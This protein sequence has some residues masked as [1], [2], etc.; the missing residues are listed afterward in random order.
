MVF[1]TTS[2]NIGTVIQKAAVDDLPPMEQ[3]SLKSN[4]KGVLM[5]KRWVFGW[6][7]TTLA[8]LLNMIALGYADITVIQ[9]LIGFGLVVL[10]VFSHYYLKEDVSRREIIGIAIAIV[11]VIILG[12]AASESQEFGSVDEVV[13]KYVQTSAWIVFAVFISSIAVLWIWSVKTEYKF[14]GI[15]FA[16]IAASFSVLGLT[17][18]K[19]AF[20]IIEKESLIGALSVWQTYLLLLLFITCSTLAIG[21]QQLSL[22]KGKSVVVTPVFN[23]A[24]IVLPLATGSMVFGE[25]IDAVKII[26]TITILMGAFFLSWKTSSVEEVEEMAEEIADEIID[27]EEKEEKSQ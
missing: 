11:G 25:V 6:V 7:M 1:S 2:M 27:S 14:A 5:N 19:G 13:S 24:S 3:E 10:V 17:F 22:Q 21:L 12:L 20:T 18:S 26:A 15:T 23:L 4:V 9:P 8:M 16:L